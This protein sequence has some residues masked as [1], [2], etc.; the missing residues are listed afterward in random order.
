M[1]Q[2]LAW[3]GRTGLNGA[4]WNIDHLYSATLHLQFYNL[5]ENF[6]LIGGTRPIENGSERLPNR[7][8]PLGRYSVTNSGR[9]IDNKAE[10]PNQNSVRW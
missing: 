5:Q 9:F 6:N 3:P 1:L 10:P 4:G 2:Y 7:F 8:L